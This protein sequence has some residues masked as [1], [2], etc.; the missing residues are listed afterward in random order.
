M[1][2]SVAPTKTSADISTQ[3]V[4]SLYNLSWKN[5]PVSN[6][7]AVPKRAGDESAVTQRRVPRIGRG[8]PSM[9]KLDA[10]FGE[11]MN[12]PRTTCG[13]PFGPWPR[14]GEPGQRTPRI[15][16][17]KRRGVIEC[18]R[19]IGRR[20]QRTN[21]RGD[22]TRWHARI[23]CQTGRC[24]LRESRRPFLCRDL[25]RASVTTVRRG[26]VTQESASP[27]PSRWCNF[28]EGT[29]GVSS[30]KIFEISSRVYAE[31]TTSKR[32]LASPLTF[33]P[34]PDYDETVV[35]VLWWNSRIIGECGGSLWKSLESDVRPL[36]KVEFTK[37]TWP[38]DPRF[39]LF[40][41]FFLHLYECVCVCVCV[42]GKL[43]VAKR[44]TCSPR[45]GC[46]QWRCCCCDNKNCPVSRWQRERSRLV[47]ES[48]ARG[49]ISL[50]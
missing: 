26:L 25:V 13:M 37:A 43:T 18:W 29:L 34:S 4:P 36:A 38:G 9:I 46:R 11:F 30:S 14:P 31:G 21:G 35:I 28:V 33:A 41:W 32:V 2:S 16:D 40:P 44:E 1:V 19:R 24:A 12:D 42:S 5:R 39:S 17:R 27:A 8:S 49:G 10:S 20:G 3:L 6:R 47:L 7:P 22:V 15:A 50:D 48:F 45:N 23:Y